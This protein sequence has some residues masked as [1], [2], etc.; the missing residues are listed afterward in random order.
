MSLCT[1]ALDAHKGYELSEVGTPVIN[2]NGTHTQPTPINVTDPIYKLIKN[3]PELHVFF[4]LFNNLVVVDLL[5]HSFSSLIRT[6]GK[7]VIESFDEN[8]FF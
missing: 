7:S 8:N 5:C 1:N 2:L 4:F 6:L 3:G